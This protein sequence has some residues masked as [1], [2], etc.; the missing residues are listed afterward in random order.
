MKLGHWILSTIV[1]ASVRAHAQPLFRVHVE[2]DRP[3]AVIGMLESAGFEAWVAGDADRAVELVV[4]GTDLAD[5]RSWGLKPTVI[6]RSRPFAEIQRARGSGRP[7]PPEY[8]TLSEIVSSMNAT[9]AAHPGIARVVDLT[10]ELGA[11]PT[12][13]GRHIFAM[14]ISD[15]V[16]IDEDEPASLLVS[17]HHA[18][19]IVTPVIA[20]HVIERL[21]TGYG[22]D[23]ALTDLIDNNDI[24]IVPTW[25]PDGYEY[26]FTTNNMWRKNRRNNGNGSFGVDLNRNYPFGWS[27]CGG[28][29]NPWSEVY[30]GPFAASEPETQTMV[31]FSQA[32]RFARVAD[33]HSSGREVRYGYGC[34]DHPWAGFMSDEAVQL[35]IASGYGGSTRRSCC[36]GGDFAYH[37]SATGSYSYLWET[38]TQFQPPF[39]SALEEAAL[40]WPGMLALFQRAAPLS[41]HVTD[42]GGSPIEASVTFTQVGFTRGERHGSDATF[43]RYHAFPPAGVYNVEF[44]AAGFTPQVHTVSISGAGVVLDVSLSPECY[45]DCDGSGTLDIFDFLCFQN[46]FVLGEPYACGCDAST[47]QLVC[48]VFDFLCFQDAFVAGCP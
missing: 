39:A 26:V 19:E 25:N 33:L 47:G 12:H 45:A 40:V 3:A 21:T 23:P 20:L 30:S 7:E 2:A 48:D 13:E 38:A 31:L 28:S 14:R 5:L 1:F 10:T 27:Q 32:R 35:S 37:I 17:N 42:A 41:G 46:S 4:S 29:S 43:G 36:L 16:G 44:S 15:N 18:R 9:A 8:P 11:P 24:W 6:E 22:S 34:W